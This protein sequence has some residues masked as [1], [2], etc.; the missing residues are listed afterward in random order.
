VGSEFAEVVGGAALAL[1]AA[2]NPRVLMMPGGDIAPNALPTLRRLLRPAI[3][4][5]GLL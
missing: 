1:A 5:S 3:A 2:A 4:R